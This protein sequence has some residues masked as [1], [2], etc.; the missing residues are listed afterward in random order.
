M[1]H[2]LV[3][4]QKA[5]L[6][7]KIDLNEVILIQAFAG[8]GKTF[9]LTEKAKLLQRMA[10]S[11]R[12]LY[13]AYNKDIVEESRGKFPSNVIVQTT[14]SLAHRAV[15]GPYKEAG[16]LGPPIRKTTVRNACRE[17]SD[18][19]VNRRRE[20]HP[21]YN[22]LRVNKM[23]WELSN[24]IWDTLCT[25]LYSGAKTILAEHIPS[26]G[27][28]LV[29]R[30][31]LVT[32]IAKYLWKRMQD[33]ED[34]FPMTHDGY[35][36][37]YE[38]TNPRLDK[39]YQ[40]ILFDE[41]QD[42][43]G[44]TLSIIEQAQCCRIY[45]G[46]P[47]QQI[48]SWRGSVNAFDKLQE[49]AT[50][51]YRLTRSFRFNKKVADWATA[52]L[53]PWKQEEAPVLGVEA[54]GGVYALSKIAEKDK[55]EYTYIA[56]T[57]A[58]IFA[59][60]V[61][62]LGRMQFGFAGKKPRD[63]FNDLLDVFFLSIYD[64]KNM[65]NQYYKGFES[66]AALKAYAAQAEDFE[67]NYLCKL[68]DDHGSRLPTLV[69][70]IMTEAV[71]ENQAHVVLTTGHRSKGRQWHFVELAPDFLEKFRNR[72]TKGK[73]GLPGA[74]VLPDYYTFSRKEE[75]NLLYVAI[76]RAKHSA[77]VPDN[78]LKM[79]TDHYALYE[80]DKKDKIK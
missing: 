61:S 72:E 17:W 38:L 70:N 79:V 3:P 56:R 44:A 66:F 58:T 22:W 32:G 33:L 26:K 5:I 52:I 11:W 63:M 37:L 29:V 51:N 62:C 40:V 12:I 6:Q 19:I 8:S 71:P 10:P 53:R 13:L 16:K 64:K 9:I 60:A 23:S 75:A 47:H 36:K 77:W 68:V 73:K 69:E 80:A 25:F 18:D 20:S 57:N 42:A 7:C 41:A 49:T 24:L 74:P 43:N 4:E 46:D 1:G 2:E 65:K 35:L 54:A 21:D 31:G 67:V 76:T 27:S 55:P 14:H 34:T 39:K 28:A 78:I 48:Y 59:K 30:S 50:Q 45:V 15:A